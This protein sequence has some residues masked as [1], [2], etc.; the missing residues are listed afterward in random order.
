VLHILFIKSNTKGLKL[1]YNAE[2]LELYCQTRF[3]GP[4]VVALHEKQ[5]PNS[6]LVNF[7]K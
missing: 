1:N 5:D 7:R 6:G 4:L 2:Q 3:Y